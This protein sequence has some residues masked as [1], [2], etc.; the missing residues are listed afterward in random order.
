VNSDLDVLW[1]FDE[2]CG[3]KGF[4]ANEDEKYGDSDIQNNPQCDLL[5]IVVEIKLHHLYVIIKH[6]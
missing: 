3:L 1:C 2:N 6:I 5:N 4:I